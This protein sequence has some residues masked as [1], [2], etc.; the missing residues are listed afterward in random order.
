MGLPATKF[1]ESVMDEDARLAIAVLQAN[2][3]NTD[4]NL[5]RLETKIDAGFAEMRTGFKEIRDDS[6]RDL[7]WTMSVFV[8]GMLFVLGA[9]ATGFFWL[10]DR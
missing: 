5:A 3:K 7:K 4:A 8:G 10:V 6:K 2:A 1:E 9:M